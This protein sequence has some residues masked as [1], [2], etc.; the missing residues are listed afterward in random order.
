MKAN[1]FNRMK[2]ITGTALVIALMTT[3]CAFAAPQPRDN[4]GGRDGGPQMMQ[5]APA[6]RN[7]QPAP[8]RDDGHRNQPRQQYRPQPEPQRR[9]GDG[10]GVIAGAVI[11]AIIG[12]LA[13]QNR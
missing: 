2:K 3:G 9:G 10:G 12:S 5:P 11:G 13:S 6:H 1:F 4:F 7:M 8:G